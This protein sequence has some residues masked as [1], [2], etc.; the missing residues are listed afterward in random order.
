MQADPR[1]VGHTEVVLL[2]SAEPRE[3]A[4]LTSLQINAQTPQP[5]TVLMS[6]PGSVVGKFAGE[7]TKDQ[8]IAKL[9]AAS[10]CGPNCSCH[11]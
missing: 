7:V 11:H 4:F 1:Y 6:P 10:S 9:Q 5:V 8:L 3:A 2:N